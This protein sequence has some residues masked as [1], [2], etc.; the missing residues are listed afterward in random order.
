MNVYEGSN[1]NLQNLTIQTE[2]VG[3]VS[4]LFIYIVFGGLILRALLPSSHSSAVWFAWGIAILY[5]LGD[6]IHQVFVPG[7]EFQLEDLAIDTFGSLIG[8]L[9]YK[10]IASRTRAGAI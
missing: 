8:I 4:H 2:L 6:E 5:S 7:R 10:W 9:I 3:E 1:I